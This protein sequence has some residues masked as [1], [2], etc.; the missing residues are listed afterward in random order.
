MLSRISLRT[1]LK[2][3]V[4][5]GSSLPRQINIVSAGTADM[6]AVVT[7]SVERAEKVRFTRPYLTNPFVLVTRDSPHSPLTLEDMVGR[8]LAMVI[9]NGLHDEISQDFP[10]IV[11][12]DVENPQQAMALV[13][14]GDADGAV[15]SLI[16]ARYLI[17]RHYRDRFTNHQHST[18]LSRHG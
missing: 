12:V 5:P 13:A 6:L 1:G 14:N 3:D 2:F 10:G 11:F 15:N 7:P 8:R 9:G 18:E 4:V 16:S 17:A